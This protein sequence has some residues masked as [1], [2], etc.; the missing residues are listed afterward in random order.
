M[1]TYDQPA[2]VLRLSGEWE[3]AAQPLDVETEPVFDGR[4]IA[5]CAHVQPV[6][7]P[8]QPY[9]GDH[10]RA[11]NG[12][13][14]FYRRTFT[15]LEGTSRR[16]RLRFEGVDYHAQVWLHGMPVGEHE[17]A[18]VPFTLDVTPAIRPGENTQLVRVSAPWDRPNP[19]G[20]D[21]IDHVLRGAGQRVVRARRGSHPAQRQPAGIW[22]RSGCCWT[23]R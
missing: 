8:D 1:L 14:W 2:R 19:R 7:Y 13:A 23:R 15:L 10:L 12:Q 4:R 16:A 9:W 11:V 20:S 5:E 22:R 17:G 18:F 3:L 6:L 21:P